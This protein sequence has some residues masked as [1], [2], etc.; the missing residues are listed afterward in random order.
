MH[1]VTSQNNKANSITK[2][3][4]NSSV[5]LSVNHFCLILDIR[6]ITIE[7]EIILPLN[8]CLVRYS[9]PFFGC[10]EKLQSSSIKASELGEYVF[11]E[12]C[13]EFNFATNLLQLNETFESNPLILDI[14]EKSSK[15]ILLGISTV[16]LTDIFNVIPLQDEIKI[17]IKSI[18]VL[19]AHCEKIAELMLIFSFKNLGLTNLEENLIQLHPISNPNKSING[20]DDLLMDAAYEIEV[21]KESQLKNFQSDLKQREIECVH[22]IEDRLKQKE[23]EHEN[24]LKIKLKHVYDLEEKLTQSLKNIDLKKSLL[25]EKRISLERKEKE[26]TSRFQHLD[27]EI[28]KAIDEIKLSY[29][30]EANEKLQFLEEDKKKLK[31]KIVMLEAKL[32]QKVEEVE[33]YEKRFSNLNKVSNSSLLKPKIQEQKKKVRSDSGSEPHP[34]D[35]NSK[36][37]IKVKEK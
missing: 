13:F 32:D 31:E 10:N 18:P 11:E 29:E 37:L 27:Q 26:I 4:L 2:L 8:S 5:N 22:V 20:I 36:N 6:S 17:K 3:N 16:N 21:W 14:I 28:T 9:Y 34:F 1:Q 7:T 12:G 24:N 33:K 30:S 23:I 35:L 25:E 15:N 19:N